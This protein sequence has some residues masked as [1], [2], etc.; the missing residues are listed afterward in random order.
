MGESKIENVIQEMKCLKVNIMGVCETRWKR[1]G[2]ITTEDHQI[3]YAGGKSH[4]RGVAVILVRERARC[5]LG[6][7]PLT[8]RI[9]HVKIQGRHLYHCCLWTHI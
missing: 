4:E 1:S 8:D 6:Y 9:L 7:W 5:V 2:G 3:I